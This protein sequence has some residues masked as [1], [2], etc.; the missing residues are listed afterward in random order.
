MTDRCAAIF[1]LSQ[2]SQ[3]LP[4]TLQYL[5]DEYSYCFFCGCAYDNQEAL[6]AECPGLSEED[7]D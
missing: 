6:T 1:A 4:L 5:R 7:H 3:R 2:A